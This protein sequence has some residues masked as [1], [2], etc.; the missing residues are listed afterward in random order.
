MKQ[1]F[2]IL[3]ATATWNVQ[4]QKTYVLGDQTHLCGP[5]SLAD[6]QQEPFA[7]WFS[8][9]YNV[10]LNLGAKQKWVKRL[11][12]V[13]VD[14]YLGSWCGDSRK[15]VPRFVKLWDEL[16]LDRSQLNFI[17][18]YNLEGKQKQG[19][20]GEEIGKKIFRVPTFI[21]EREEQ[22]IGRIVEFPASTLETDLAHIAFG[23]PSAPRYQAANYLLDIFE[24][25]AADGV[26]ANLNTHYH[27]LYKLVQ[28]SNELNSLG[29]LLIGKGQLEEALVVFHLNSFLFKT[30]PNVF[31]SYAE[32]LLEAGM[33]AES[34]RNYEKA[35]KMDPENENVTAQ[36]ALLME[37]MASKE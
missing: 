20:N 16:D 21:F 33:F 29:Y 26:S 32:A 2:F 23:Y 24:N 9:N 7:E 11:K 8:E 15:W 13:N 36:L 12:D 18:L 34:L 10:E 3:L 17:A 22:E 19:P 30:D 31:D 27:H 6:L 1:L 28:R 5:I 4:A 14:I 25:Q 35:L 37:K